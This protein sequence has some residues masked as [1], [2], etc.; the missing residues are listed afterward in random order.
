MERLR[1]KVSGWG[2]K[3]KRRMMEPR[4]HSYR[5]EK[6]MSKARFYPLKESCRE[7]IRS[8]FC[9]TFL[10]LKNFSIHVEKVRLN[11]FEAIHKSYNIVSSLEKQVF[12]I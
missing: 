12:K 3:E 11:P 9:S 10:L 4:E 2:S 1:K 7:F 5:R 6:K 8:F